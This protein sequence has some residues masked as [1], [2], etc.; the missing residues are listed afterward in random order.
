VVTIGELANRVRD[1]VRPG[2]PLAFDTSR[3]EGVARLS[4]Q[5]LPGCLQDYPWTPLAE[6]IRR[7]VAWW[8]ANR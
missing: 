1:L 6:G 4:R 8:A 7:T 2:L 5:P 3:Q